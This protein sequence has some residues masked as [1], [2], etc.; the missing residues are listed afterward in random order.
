MSQSA[1]IDTLVVG[2]AQ[3]IAAIVEAGCDYVESKR[4]QTD[5]GKTHAVDYVVKDQAGATVGVKVDAKSG[6][7]T[8]IPGDCQGGRGK[9]LA[10]RIAQRYAYARITEELRRKG[11]QIAKE[12]VAPD[13]TIQVTASR[14]R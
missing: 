8:F 12:Q 13:G 10:G 2:V 6:Q 9:A 11:Y 1:E 4:F 14:W 3:L 5:D 7:A